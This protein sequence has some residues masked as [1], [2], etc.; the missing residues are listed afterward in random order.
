MAAANGQPSTAEAVLAIWALACGAASSAATSRQQLPMF[1]SPD[2]L[3]AVLKRL[4]A[5]MQ[6]CQ[7]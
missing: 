6:V 5:V 1:G 4:V 7:R 2:G 3:D